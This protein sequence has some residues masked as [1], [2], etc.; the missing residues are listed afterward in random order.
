MR[1]SKSYGII[2]IAVIIG[3]L[4][5]AC[6]NVSDSINVLNGTVSITGIA[7]VGQTLT[8]ETSA[9]GGSGII[10]FQWMRGGTTVIGSDSSTYIVQ[11]ADVGFTITVNV[12][13]TGSIGNIVSAPTAVV[14]SITDPGSDPG[15]DHGSDPGGDP[16]TDP[17]SDPGTDPIVNRTPVA[18]DF[19]IGN[20]S[21]TVG[22]VTPVTI[23]PQTGK[24]TG[25]ITIYYDGL[26]ALPETAGTYEVTFDV[27]AESDWNAAEGLP[28]GTLTIISLSGITVELA[29]MNEWELTEH[30]AQATANEDRIFTVTGTYSTY[31]WYLDG[32]SVGTSSSYTFNKPSGVY[33]LVVVVTTSAGD[34][35]SARCWI[36]VPLQ[37]TVTFNDNGGSGTPPAAQAVTAGSSIILPSGRL[38]RSG[39][40]FDGWNTN[41]SGT[42]TN[43]NVGSLYTPASD[44]TLYARWLT[45][46]TVTFN[47]NDGS[48]TVPVAQ[49]VTEGSSIILPSGSRL[50]RS[51]FAFGGWNTDSSGTGTNYNDGSSYTPTGNV[52]LFAKWNEIR[53]IT[54]LMHDS[55]GD[56]W[57]SG[58]LSIR[59]NEGS[60][61]SLNI[62]SGNTR[63]FTFNADIGDFIQVYWWKGNNDHE[64][65]F[66]IYYTDNPPSPAFNPA[67]FS[68]NNTARLLVHRLYNGLTHTASN[69]FT[70]L[71]SFTVTSP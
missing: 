10:T 45:V 3:L 61:M 16:G 22:N 54:V 57:D 38:S 21:Q 11:T 63:T 51:G 14:T 48:G 68:S 29:A 32:V 28:G 7:Q 25:D 67:A 2:A 4:I 9:L 71:G 60:S 39:F 17:G 64:C 15:S 46:Y 1:K 31:Q 19:D 55:V 42:G 20:L 6:G 5:T 58:M 59:I 24:S 69:T 50:T 65:A 56:G 47:V 30:T 37:Y 40:I 62:H 44:I 52:T 27:A 33:Q 70:L 66:A 36:T 43:Y 49:T 12:S 26:E 23:T 13:R 8:A 34:S 18:S 35:R 53:N 41:S